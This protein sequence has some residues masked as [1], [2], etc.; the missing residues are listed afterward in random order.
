[1]KI[2][3]LFLALVP[4]LAA[5]G[6]DGPERLSPS[7]AQPNEVEKILKDYCAKMEGTRGIENY[8]VGKVTVEN[9]ETKAYC[10]DGKT[11]HEV[12]KNTRS[13]SEDNY[14][15]L[16]RVDFTSDKG[17]DGYAY[18]STTPGKEG[19]YYFTPKGEISDTT[20]NEGLKIVLNNIPNAVG[21]MIDN[22]P[23]FPD[24][25]SQIGTGILIKT[26]WDQA[27]LRL[28]FENLLTAPRSQVFNPLKI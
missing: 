28:L 16:S 18:L 7:P 1:M 3:K 4:L 10:F 19:V 14:F 23:Q 6:N 24:S 22:N 27:I 9:V 17:A 15:E 11:S 2:V 21:G 26:T 13:K 25:V 12:A 8:S 5:C 20:Y